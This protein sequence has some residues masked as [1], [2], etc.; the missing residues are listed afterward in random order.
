[1]PAPAGVGRPLQSAAVGYVV[2]G[3]AYVGGV[4]L[5]GAGLF[6]LMRGSFPAWWQRWFAWPLINFTPLVARLQGG[7]A[8]GL[9]VS[10]LLIVFTTVAPGSLSGSLALIAILAYLVT[11]LVFLVSIWLSRRGASAAAR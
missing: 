1:M 5:I 3:A 10:I 11:V 9:G 4:A 7:V 6:L 2:E 8:I